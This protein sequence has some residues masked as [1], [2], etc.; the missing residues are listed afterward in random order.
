MNDPMG[1]PE[2]IKLAVLYVIGALFVAAATAVL[3]L[4]FAI[5]AAGYRPALSQ[6]SSA[7]LAWLRTWVPAECCVTADC[8]FEVAPGTLTQLSQDTWRVNSTLR[9]IGRT[10][11]SKDHRFWRCA[12]DMVEGRWIANDRAFNRCVFPPPP[13]S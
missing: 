5:L 12:C 10:G 1:V 3:L 9:I 13:G 7:D 6:P 8:C 11:W 4:V 2:L